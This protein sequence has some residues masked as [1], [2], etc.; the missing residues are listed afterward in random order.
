MMEY[1]EKHSVARL[2]GAT[3]GY[4][5]YDEGGQ[6]TEAVR[7]KPCAVTLFDEI[8][9]APRTCSTLLQVPDDDRITRNECQEPGSRLVRMRLF[10]RRRLRS[11]SMSRR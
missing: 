4:V 8:E 11:V 1:I 3:P 9:K 6:L 10:R 7:W 2:S 5:G